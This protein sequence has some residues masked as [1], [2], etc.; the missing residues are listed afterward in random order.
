M[1]TQKRSEDDT[2]VEDSINGVTLDLED[3]LDELEKVDDFDQYA[4]ERNDET[5]SGDSSD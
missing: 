5:N 4:K 3:W 2:D 1:D